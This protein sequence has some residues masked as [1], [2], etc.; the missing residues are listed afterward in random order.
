MSMVKI[1]RYR[2]AISPTAT[3][4]RAVRRLHLNPTYTPIAIGPLLNG[5]TLAALSATMAMSGLTV[6]TC[7][8]LVGL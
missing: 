4:V 2:P 3:P 5:V 7:L 6:G 8:R 1:K